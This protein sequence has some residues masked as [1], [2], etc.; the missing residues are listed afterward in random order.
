[1]DIVCG[2]YSQKQ[3]INFLEIISI[4]YCNY[5]NYLFWLFP[6]NRGSGF[7]Q[8]LRHLIK[9][10]DKDKEWFSICIRGKESL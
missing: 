3:L 4:K 8:A 7:P 1:M 6:R 10:I 2:L 5:R 9:R